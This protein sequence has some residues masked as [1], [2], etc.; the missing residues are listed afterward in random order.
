MTMRRIRTLV[1]W[2]ALVAVN[3]AHAQSP[4]GTIAGVV[5][6]PAG[7]AVAGARIRLTNR[8]SG[9]NR[10]ITTSDEDNYSAAS[11]P[12]GEY[13]VEAEAPGFDAIERTATVEA[14]TTT[15]LDMR[16]QVGTVSEKISVN[17]AAPIIRYDHQVSGLVNRN[18]IENLPLNGRNFLDLAKLEP[19]VIIAEPSNN[20]RVFVPVL[21][22][23]LFTPPR[24]GNTRVTVDGASI[25]SAGTVG[26]QLQLSQE[27]VREFQISTVNFDLSTSLTSNGAINI[28]T[29]SGGNEFHGSGFYF[30]RDHNLAAYPGLGREPQDPDPFFRCSQF[31]YQIGGP[32]RRDR[33]FFFTSLERNDQQG[34]FSLQ[35]LTP[36][37]AS[38]GGIFPSPYLGNQFN[39]RIDTRLNQKHNA[40]VRYT[41]DGNRALTPDGVNVG[42]LPSAWSRLKNWVD[43]S[44]AGLTSV[45]SS[46][47]VNDLRFSYFFASTPQTPAGAEDCPD[48]L[49]VGVPR[50][51]IADA[52]VTFGQS[53][54]VSSIKRRYQLTESLA[55][56]RGSHSLRFGFDWEHATISLQLFTNEPATIQ[57]YSAREVREFNSTAP[58]SAQIPLPPTF[59]TLND[60]LRLP[61]KSFVTGIG[62]G[63]T[64][65]RDF[66]KSRKLDLYRLYAVDTWRINPRLT[67]NYG[68]AWSYEPNS[69]NTDLTKPELLTLVLG[70]SGLGAPVADKDNFSPSVGLAWDATGDAKTVIRG[71]VGLYYDPIGFNP[72]NTERE[73]LALMPAG[74]GR[75]ANIPGTSIFL[76]GRAL[77]FT[78]RPT[79]FTGAD[80]LA[81]LPEIRAELA[82]RLNSNNRDFAFRNLDLDKLGA[83]LSDPLFETPYAIHLNLGVQRELARD[84]VLSADFAW[85]RF[86]H[87]YLEG[88]D[89]NRF[90]RRI[91]SVQ[92]PVIPRCAPPQRN[93]LTAVCSLGPITFDNTTGIAEY[94]GLL[95]RAEKRFSR[96]IQ[97]LVSYALGSFEGSNGPGVGTGF[98]NEDW[99]ENFGPLPTDLRHILN[100][101]GFIE[102]PWRFQLSFNAAVYSKPPFS[103][104]VSG[105]D[106]NG[107]GTRDDLLPGTSV[108]QFNRGFDKADLARL[109]ESYNRQFAGK[110]TLGGQVAPHITLPDDYSFNDGFFTQDL[111]L[112]RR[113]L[114]RGESVRLVLFGEVFNLFNTSNLIGYDGNIA[115][116]AEFGQARSRFS[117]VFGSGGPRAF[118]LGA[119]ISF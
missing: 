20:N 108:H 45:L 92:T 60:I 95:V 59:T 90:N 100:L 75:R 50:V 80:L 119:R 87:T 104:Y 109:V 115:N 33:A 14:G 73:R 107:D 47:I 56:Q 86:L 41:H 27:V 19:G 68:L 10:T 117:Q 57:L 2:L 24:I 54:Q 28:V 30:Y 4:T 40:F 11:L 39:L 29:R 51:N 93:D 64:P 102:L 26:P 118:Q 66:N 25:V 70:P 36:E 21:G 44:I 79:A 18:Q 76:D 83:N 52:G 31:G 85:R 9:L 116:S 7:A 84:L 49:G 113:F 5:T 67:V 15:K 46:G 65:Q 8:A 6:D 88:I 96:W 58:P 74:T 82:R 91:N 111:R 3:S 38:L 106:F 23:G 1:L 34:V 32:I 112:G 97:F 110:Q 105:V 81:L 101:S 13:Q 62:P 48:C 17:T 37:F 43:Q 55:W 71:G 78:S 103:A 72:A 22:T 98:N 42:S 99:F 69:L 94:K 16:L 77:G 63:L 35:P 53:R 61:L 89:Y 114:L 12:P